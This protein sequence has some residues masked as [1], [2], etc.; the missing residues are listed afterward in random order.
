VASPEAS[1]I[2][3][4]KTRSP[5]RT[6]LYHREAGY[7]YLCVCTTAQL[8]AHT[9]QAHR[10]GSSGTQAS[11]WYLSQ[12]FKF[13]YSARSNLLENFVHRRQR[14]TWI[15][16]YAQSN[17]LELVRAWAGLVSIVRALFGSVYGYI[18]NIAGLFIALRTNR[19]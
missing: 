6:P 3:Q 13:Q 18:M 9:M 11:F 15:L 5:R 4:Q 8:R 17:G 2:S 16:H 19:L 10:C 14:T 1:F 12:L 7:A